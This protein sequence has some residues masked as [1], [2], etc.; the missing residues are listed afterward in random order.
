MAQ[1]QRIYL[2]MQEMWVQFLV[3]EDPTC[4]A[5]K[6]VYPNYC[7]CALEPGSYNHG[8][9]SVLDPTAREATA[10]RSPCTAKNSPCSPQLEKA[11][12]QQQRPST[13]INLKKKKT[14][15]HS[16][17]PPTSTHCIPPNTQAICISPRTNDCCFKP[18]SLG[19]ILLIRVLYAFNTWKQNWIWKCF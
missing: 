14:N 18:L 4:G 6:P 9:P 3:R 5:T 2:P 11:C 1:W 13:I 10:V 19:L 12:T 15:P 8:S 16:K 17:F 7:A